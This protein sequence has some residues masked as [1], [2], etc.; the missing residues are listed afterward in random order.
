MSQPADSD[1]KGQKPSAH[2]ARPHHVVLDGRLSSDQKASALDSF[3]QDHRQLAEASSERMG[4]GES[5]KLHDVLRAKDAHAE[6]V[7][8]D[9]YATALR[10]LQLRR[11]LAAAPATG[12]LF[13]QAIFAL[14]RLAAPPEH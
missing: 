14:G 5:A 12:V 2:F 6:A 13:D 4:G 11:K 7:V 8:T 1:A 3:E 9:A 10:D